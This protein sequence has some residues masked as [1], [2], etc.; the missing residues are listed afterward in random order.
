M[1]STADLFG[2]KGSARTPRGMIPRWADRYG[3]SVRLIKKWLA[4]GREAEDMPPLEEP[5]KMAAW[6]ERVLG[7]VPNRLAEALESLDHPAKAE[8]PGA[9]EE[10]PAPEVFEVPEVRDDELGIEQQLENFRREMVMLQKLRRGALERGEF[11]RADGYLSSM[12]KVSQEIRQLE[13]LLPSLKREQGDLKSTDEVRRETVGALKVL[14]TALFSRGQ[15][16]RQ[17]L[18]E[19]AD[20][21]EAGRIYVEEIEA[22]FREA[23]EAGFEE[24]LVLE[25]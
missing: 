4:A 2:A 12:G 25:S 14:R 19:V 17:R 18:A 13:K 24:Q 11:S 20:E 15:K 8:P 3:Y 6:A 21:E 5:E 23:A 22:A 1:V 9:K 10:D 7:K 16:A